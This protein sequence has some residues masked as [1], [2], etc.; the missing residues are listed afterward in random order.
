[1]QLPS[2]YALLNSD[3]ERDAVVVDKQEHT[4]TLIEST[5]AKTNSASRLSCFVNLANTI[6]GSGMLGLPY[7]FSN[8][9]WILGSVLLLLSAITT[10]F[11]LHCLSVCALKTSV[12]SSFYTVTLATIPQFTFLIDLSV[13]L[14]CFGV[15]ISYLIVVGG[16]MPAVMAQFG[17]TDMVWRSRET[18]VVIGFIVVF[19]L[20]CLRNLDALRYTSFFAVV[21]AAFLAVLIFLYAVPSVGLDACAGYD[22]TSGVDCVGESVLA[23]NSLSVLRVFSIFIFANTCQQ[24]STHNSLCYHFSFALPISKA[25]YLNASEYLC[26]SQ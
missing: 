19:P 14:A 23:V 4:T 1:M 20:C 24:V 15:G 21:C 3:E 11:S 10:V 22:E 8:T 16:L 5:G 18:W 12:P 2:T 13:V 17:V 26:G 6:V 9:G 25:S 7:A